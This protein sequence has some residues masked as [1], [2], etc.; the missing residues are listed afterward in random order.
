MSESEED[1]IRNAAAYDIL[2]DRAL[3]YKRNLFITSF[4]TLTVFYGDIT[5]NQ[6]SLSGLK[7]TLPNADSIIPTGVLLILLY[8]LISFRRHSHGEYVLWK[9]RIQFRNGLY[10]INWDDKKECNELLDAAKKVQRTV[11]ENFELIITDGQPFNVP[12]GIQSLSSG[13]HQEIQA[14][15]RHYRI[16]EYGLPM[17]VGALSLSLLLVKM[18]TKLL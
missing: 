2:S 6:I 5:S 10:L 9:E 4:L 8:Y 3:R 13:L 15:M 17:L 12:D 7:F 14:R 1:K 18:T 16:V 11:N